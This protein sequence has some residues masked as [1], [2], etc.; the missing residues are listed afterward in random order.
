MGIGW[1]D[2]IDSRGSWVSLAQ[3]L[4]PMPMPTELVAVD[5]YCNLELYLYVLS[6]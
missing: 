1:A 6:A 5:V 4:I 2:R 3:E